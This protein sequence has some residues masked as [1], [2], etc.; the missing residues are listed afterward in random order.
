MQQLP[1]HWGCINLSLWLP[2]FSRILQ[3]IPAALGFKSSLMTSRWL[4][5][6]RLLPTPWA[7][8]PKN[9]FANACSLSSPRI[10][11]TAAHPC[12]CFGAIGGSCKSRKGGLGSR[13]M[14]SK[15]L[16]LLRGVRCHLSSNWNCSCFSHGRAGVMRVPTPG[17][18][19]VR[20]TKNELFQE[21][22]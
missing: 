12:R 7:G 2:V 3:N 21:E 22:I 1:Y 10:E 20:R 19:E 5:M 11:I 15:V 14:A 9:G 18:E 13:E 16:L 6:S 8:M 4:G 17:M